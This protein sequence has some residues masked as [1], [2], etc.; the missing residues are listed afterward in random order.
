MSPTIKP[1]SLK[2]DQAQINPSF[3]ALRL[4]LRKKVL[5]PLIIK[6]WDDSLRTA[7]FAYLYLIAAQKVGPR[8]VPEERLKLLRTLWGIGCPSF[9]DLGLKKDSPVQVSISD[10]NC[11]VLLTEFDKIS[12]T[13]I[14]TRYKNIVLDSDENDISTSTE[15][16][17][18]F[19][20][21]ILALKKAIEKDSGL[22]VLV[23]DVW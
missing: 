9:N 16:C 23:Q 18:Y 5:K 22:V 13:D 8:L 7:S 21:W 17:R 20:G 11:K 15:F 12:L 19:E 1:Y 3:D 10:A 14:E 4:L 6:S 2:W